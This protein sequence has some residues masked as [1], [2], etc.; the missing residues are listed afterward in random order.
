MPLMIL[1]ICPVCGYKAAVESLHFKTLKCNGCLIRSPRR[2]W[3]IQI[4]YAV[5]HAATLKK[6]TKKKG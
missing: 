5:I 4:D 6:L 2:K 1:L 3:Y